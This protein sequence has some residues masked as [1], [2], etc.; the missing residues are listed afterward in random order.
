MTIVAGVLAFKFQPE[1][2][3]KKIGRDGGGYFIAIGSVGLMV[4]LYS[5]IYIW[6]G[7]LLLCMYV[8]YVAY[9]VFSERKDAAQLAEVKKGDTN[10]AQQNNPAFDA[11]LE[12]A[13]APAEE[14][15]LLVRSDA[16]PIPMWECPHDGSWQMTF[17]RL[18]AVLLDTCEEDWEEKTRFGK[19]LV[20]L[21]APLHSMLIL[22]CPSMHHGDPMLTWD[23]NHHVLTTFFMCPFITLI[24]KD[25]A[26]YAGDFQVAPM[27]L[28][29]I[30]GVVLAFFVR[31]SSEVETP[32][33][34]Q[35][36]FAAV[37]F[38]VAL[39]WIYVLSDEIVAVLR[40]CGIML[41][42]SPALIGMTILGIGNGSCDLVA[43]YLMAR[44][45]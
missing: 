11:T 44:A 40:T 3:L 9:V 24:F 7:V 8:A 22:T 15:P 23:R 33:K 43:N 34:W 26:F 37:G 2:S 28:A 38:V 21:Q 13:I 31:M 32:P 27:L 45:G 17:D 20:I 5:A 30:V 29:C 19:A 4:Y 42:I 10:A 12:S 39:T 16:S 18:K 25:D 36:A 6:S 1:I 35:S 14:D 41:T